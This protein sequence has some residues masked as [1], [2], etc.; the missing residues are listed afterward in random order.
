VRR[1][2]LGA[3]LRVIV[4][5]ALVACSSSPEVRRAKAAASYA[6]QQADCIAKNQT[7]ETIDACRDRVKALWAGDASVGARED[8]R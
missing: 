5:L 8:A 2:L 3:V 6:A 1:L 4:A 7:R